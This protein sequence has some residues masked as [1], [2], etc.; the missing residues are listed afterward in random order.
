VVGV[1]GT[2]GVVAVGIRSRRIR[3]VAEVVV[4]AVVEVGMQ[5]ERWALV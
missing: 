5:R 2:V 1:V 3:V 4:G